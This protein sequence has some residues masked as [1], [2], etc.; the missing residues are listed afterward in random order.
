MS[1]KGIHIKDIL[2]NSKYR[3]SQTDRMYP[4]GQGIK[5]TALSKM[6]SRA[7]NQH[8]QGKEQR[9]SQGKNTDTG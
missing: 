4:R 8:L 9:I 5:W 2:A 7:T 6:N 1:R 3:L